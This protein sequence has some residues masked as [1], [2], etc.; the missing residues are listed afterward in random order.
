MGRKM[1]KEKTIDKVCDVCMFSSVSSSIIINKLNRKVMFG[2]RT[3]NIQW[4]ENQSIASASAQ[5]KKK[6]MVNTRNDKKKMETER[7]KQTVLKMCGGVRSVSW[8]CID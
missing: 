3:R 1:K 7:K 4:S 8:K 2:M 6:R 5:K